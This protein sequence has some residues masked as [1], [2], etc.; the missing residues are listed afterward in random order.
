MQ[1]AH[2]IALVCNVASP[3]GILLLF[4]HLPILSLLL[5]WMMR[6]CATEREGKNDASGDTEEEEKAKS[7]NSKRMIKLH[8][9]STKREERLNGAIEH[10]GPVC[11]KG[12]RCCNEMNIFFIVLFSFFFAFSC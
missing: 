2:A 6:V 9:R 4:P 12:P 8:H 3:K 5:S 11:K 10:N 7:R 1:G